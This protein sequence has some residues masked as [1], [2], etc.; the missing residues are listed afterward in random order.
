[1]IAGAAKVPVVCGS[2][3]FTVG[4]ADATVHVENDH[5][6]WVA[7]MDLV[8]PH[9][10][11]AGQGFNVR[12]ACQKLRLEAPHLAAGRSLSFDGLAS[13][14]PAHGGSRPRRSASFTSS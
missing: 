2:F 3:L 12:V 5:L 8:D 6:R 11:H 10:V 14:N 4:R 7:V 1:M 9:P 13:N